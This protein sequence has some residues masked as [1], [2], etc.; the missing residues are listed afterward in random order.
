[1]WF[2]LEFIL[3][4]TSNFRGL[5]LS[6]LFGFVKSVYVQKY[7]IGLY[8]DSIIALDSLLPHLVVLLPHF[9]PVRASPIF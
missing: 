5:K 4:I 9:S 7:G 2:H 1:M 3:Q 6:V 8:V